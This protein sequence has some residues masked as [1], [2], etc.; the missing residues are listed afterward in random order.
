M[1]N[2]GP[3]PCDRGGPIGPVC[4]SFSTVP[5]QQDSNTFNEG[6]KGG[7]GSRM[8][9]DVEDNTS[10]HDEGDVGRLQAIAGY[11]KE[12]MRV[13]SVDISARVRDFDAKKAVDAVLEAPKRLKR[14]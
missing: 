3:T 12:R 1:L 9:D 13:A 4:V 14:E 7:L 11:S 8:A 10:A 2:T 6:L 5:S